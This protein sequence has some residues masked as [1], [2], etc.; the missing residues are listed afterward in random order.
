MYVFV[1]MLISDRGDR[2]RKKIVIKGDFL[3]YWE[4]VL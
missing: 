1:D 4:K 2:F 3:L